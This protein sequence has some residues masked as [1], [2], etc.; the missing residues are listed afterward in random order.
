MN[1]ALLKSRNKNRYIYDGHGNSFFRILDES[2]TSEE[3]NA[4]IDAK[5]P[6]NRLFAID[7]PSHAKKLATIDA[8][9]LV[10]EVTERCNLRC[11]YC[12]YGKASKKNRSH[13]DRSI[14][15]NI[16]R[17][18][19]RNFL[20][21]C[22]A[23]PSISYY[24]GEPLLEFDLIKQLSEYAK[25]LSPNKVRFGVTSNGLLLKGGVI[26]YLVENQFELIISIDGN[27]EIND[28]ARHFGKGKN[29][30]VWKILTRNL[31]ALIQR[32]PD[33]YRTNISFHC[34]ITDFGKIDSICDFFNTCTLTADNQI[35]FSFEEEYREKHQV[36]IAY[37]KRVIKTAN[38]PL[39]YDNLNAFDREFIYGPIKDIEEREIGE[40]LYENI[41]V[42]SPF[43]N[44]TFVR[45][46]GEVQIC[47]RVGRKYTRVKPE[48]LGRNA[49][50]VMN[51][52]VKFYLKQCSNCY[53]YHFC[54]LCPASFIDERG[55]LNSKKRESECAFMKE[56][57]QLLLTLFISN[58]E[59]EACS[60][61][62]TQSLT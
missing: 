56:K 39:D 23:D 44:R 31:T 46:N 60:A 13:S 34:V 43:R 37:L 35:L 48:N 9:S 6:K 62:D 38:L 33:Y 20:G 15:P 57:L 49:Y 41:R 19:I 1:Y 30:S 4:F 61:K 45:S 25:G 10:V 14:D 28:A 54:G 50:E 24:G 59:A 47:E 36:Q 11:A 18:E 42:C 52:L 27:E 22:K 21:R 7:A 29:T 16:A 17:A 58:K 2:L 51:E 55:H 40:G 53:A 26:D 8:R 12:T 3:I 5:R 32:F